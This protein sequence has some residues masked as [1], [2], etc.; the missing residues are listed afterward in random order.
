MPDMY[1]NYG[2]AKQM[3][4]KTEEI[5]MM[6]RVAMMFNRIEEEACGIKNDPGFGAS[7]ALFLKDV[8]GN[9]GLEDVI[10]NETA[11]QLATLLVISLDDKLSDIKQGMVSDYQDARAFID[12][13]GAEGKMLKAE[14]LD[15]LVEKMEGME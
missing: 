1:G 12:K 8:I 14:N 3:K 10:H 11:C 7:V 4:E 9:D 5:M 15:D 2:N 13:M 6:N